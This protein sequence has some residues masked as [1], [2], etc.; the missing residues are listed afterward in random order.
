MKSK[1][2]IR[3]LDL[4]G[5]RLAVGFS[6][7]LDH[8]WCPPALVNARLGRA[9]WQEFVC[10][11]KVDVRM[12]LRFLPRVEFRVLEKL[13][14]V[15]PARS[16]AFDVPEFGDNWKLRFESFSLVVLG[17]THLFLAKQGYTMFR[18][19]TEVPSEKLRAGTDFKAYLSEALSWTSR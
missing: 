6:L 10:L 3:S 14:L 15:E 17:S 16:L 4:E 11:S 18:W 13:I 7:C 2:L 9:K 8:S 1:E 19:S 5:W 12:A